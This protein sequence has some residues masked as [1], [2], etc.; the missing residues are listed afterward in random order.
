VALVLE[1]IT[2]LANAQAS[3][4][5]E[6]PERQEWVE[7]RADH[8]SFGQHAADLDRSATGGGSPANFRR[9]PFRAHRLAQPDIFDAHASSLLGVAEYYREVLSE[10]IALWPLVVQMV[11]TFM[12]EDRAFR[13]WRRQRDAGRPESK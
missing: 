5:R 11:G 13:M 7:R 1:Q 9:Y 6:R 12:D 4:A 3:V 8:D 10:P 2:Q